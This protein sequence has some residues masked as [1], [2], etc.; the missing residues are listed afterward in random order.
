MGI[1]M[2]PSILSADFMNLERDVRNISEHGADLIHFDV[3]DGHFVPNLTLGVPFVKAM[4]KITSTPLDVHL[5]IDNPADQI[6]WYL[7]AGADI[8]TV[9]VEAFDSPSECRGLLHHIRKRGARSGIAI[10]PETPASKL[11]DVLDQADVLLVMSVHPGFG[12]QSFIESTPDK[13]SE[14]VEFCGREGLSPL[15]EVDG[16]INANTAPLVTERGARALVAGNAVFGQPDHVVAME[17][18]RAAGEAGAR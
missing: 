6:D 17:A 16:G 13:I 4:K 8:A 14:I 3:M 15:I 5:M 9:H 18:I 1:L 11:N 10:N 2:A 7:D 12:G